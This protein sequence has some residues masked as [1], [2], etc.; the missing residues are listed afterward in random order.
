[1]YIKVKVQAGAK[2]EKIEK[3]KENSFAIAVKEPAERNLANNRIKEIIAS[4]YEINIK[5]VR[6]I[7]GHQTPSKILSIIIP[8]D[9]V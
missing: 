2:K 4:I 1:M 9:L 5:S 7:S 6:I 3:K 8:S